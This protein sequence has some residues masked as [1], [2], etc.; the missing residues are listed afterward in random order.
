MLFLKSG[1]AILVLYWCTRTDFF[2]VSLLNSLWQLTH[3]NMLKGR[4][5]LIELYLDQ[6]DIECMRTKLWLSQHV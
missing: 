5:I 1:H 3:T 2:S 4:F 6:Q